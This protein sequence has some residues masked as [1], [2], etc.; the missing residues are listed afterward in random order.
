MQ[1][2]PSLDAM[3]SSINDVNVHGALM[4]VAWVGLVPLAIILA[5]HK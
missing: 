4:V 1:Y 3:S 2:F 5:R